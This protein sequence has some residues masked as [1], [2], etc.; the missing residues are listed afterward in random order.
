VPNAALLGA[1]AALTNM[2][3]LAAVHHAIGEKFSGKI[4]AANSAAATAAHQALAHAETA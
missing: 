3:S 4:A 2:V 1:F